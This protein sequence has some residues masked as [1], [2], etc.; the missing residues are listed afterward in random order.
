MYPPYSLKLAPRDY[1]QLL[2]I[3][4]YLGGEELASRKASENQFFN[5]MDI[6]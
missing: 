1:Y 2:S 6:I 3:A 4:I 5:H